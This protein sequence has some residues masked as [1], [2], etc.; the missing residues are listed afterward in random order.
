MKVSSDGQIVEHADGLM[1]HRDRIDD[2]QKYQD[3]CPSRALSVVGEEPTV[4]QVVEQVRQDMPFYVGSGGGVTL[5]GG[6]PYDQPEFLLELLAALKALEIHVAVETSLATPWPR[7]EASL[8]YVD[9]FLA[10]LPHMDEAVYRA[11]TG[12]ELGTVLE[13]LQRL[14]EAE[15]PVNV[16][17][18]VI[19][20]F[21][22]SMDVMEKLVALAASM[23]NVH[24]IDFLPFHTLGVNKYELLGRRYEYPCTSGLEDADM[25]QYV[26]LARGK[27]LNA[28]LGG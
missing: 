27:G 1:I 12:G 13:S 18:T 14:D 7:V 22:D 21:N 15:A 6:E 20:G 25:V 5:S 4:E 28:R 24:D 8:Q 23:N 10:D 17:V 2:P 9:L 19:P 3:I 26:E 16:R 11:F